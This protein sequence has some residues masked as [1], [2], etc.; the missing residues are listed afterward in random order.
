MSSKI[1][2]L[3]AAAVALVAFAAAS[4]SALG[5]TIAQSPT[6]NSLVSNG[7]LTFSNEKA[8]IECNVTLNTSDTASVTKVT[9]ASLGTVTG[10]SWAN[11]VGGNVRA[12]LNTPWTIEYNSIAGTLP[13][14]V[15]SANLTL[16]RTQFQFSLFFGLVNCLYEGD[17]PSIL[18]LNH[19][20]GG[21]YT[22]GSLRADETANQRYVSG[23]TECPAT[24][25]MTGTFNFSST[26]TITRT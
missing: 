22:A 13:E 9:G 1:K 8:T 18:T 2:M 21:T 6:T 15:T 4:S 17:A 23:P 10:V 12:V 25:H 14:A 26:E 24:G 3:V 20:T 19:R 7:K 11:C 5:A 16:K